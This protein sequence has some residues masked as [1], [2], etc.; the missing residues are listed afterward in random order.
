MELI[1][2]LLERSP[3]G[4]GINSMVDR[5][6]TYRELIDSEQISRPDQRYLNS[7]LNSVGP[8]MKEDFVPN[9]SGPIEKL[10]GYVDAGRRL[11]GL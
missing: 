5:I 3:E 9:G 2:T 8:Q 1:L 11:V 10:V 7:L 6:K 4:K